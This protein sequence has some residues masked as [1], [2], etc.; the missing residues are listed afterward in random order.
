MSETHNREDA[1]NLVRICTKCADL[2]NDF[3]KLEEYYISKKSKYI[4][5][6]L[7][8]AFI[9]LGVYVEA[10][11]T[12]LLQ[13]IVNADA[14]AQM[15]VQKLFVDASK[16]IMIIN[17]EITSLILCYAKAKSIIFDIDNMSY[18]DYNLQ[19]LR[20]KCSNF[21]TLVEKKYRSFLEMTDPNGVPVSKIVD[22]MNEIGK[23]IK[24]Q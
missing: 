18:S 2:L 22:L 14:D 3:D 4:K 20:I 12:N 23:S 19:T 1:L 21:A 7:K 5:Q 8:K 13:R 11:S 9:E 17:E 10:F 6:E 24:Y 16:K 15:R